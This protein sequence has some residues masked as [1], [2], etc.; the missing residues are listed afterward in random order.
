MLVCLCVC[1]FL[2]AFAILDTCAPRCAQPQSPRQQGRRA[3][4]YIRQLLRARAERVLN[5]SATSTFGGTGRSNETQCVTGDEHLLIAAH[6][7]ILRH[8]PM[9]TATMSSRGPLLD[10]HGVGL[11]NKAFFLPF[12]VSRSSYCPRS[13]MFLKARQVVSFVYSLQCE[14]LGTA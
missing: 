3:E 1:V 10:S 9:R 4:S 5:R 6:P 11:A 7:A 12:F 8:W 2:S 14:C 13:F